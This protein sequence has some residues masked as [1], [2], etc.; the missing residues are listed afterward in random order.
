MLRFQHARMFPGA[1]M[2]CG[3]NRWID[4]DIKESADDYR[5]SIEIPGALKDDVKIWLED[6]ILTV[7]GE[8]KEVEKEGLKKIHSER[9]F[10]KFERSFRLPN[11]VDGNKVRAE[12]VN[13]I[14]EV[15][16]PKSEK[17]KPIN[18]SIN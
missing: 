18:V 2:R 5:L 14:L 1:Q 4:V 9:V 11:D 3:E 17:S 15:S 6:N 12:F 10:G 16:I 8:K 7:S 13:G